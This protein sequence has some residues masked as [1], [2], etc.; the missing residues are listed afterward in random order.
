MIATGPAG[1]GIWHVEFC[2]PEKRN[3]LGVASYAAFADALAAASAMADVRVVL[4][5]GQGST[6]CAGND[7]AE[8]ATEW[9]QPAGGPVIRFLHALA[10]VPVPVVAAVQGGA[11]GIGATM[12]LHCDVIVA[13]PDAFLRYPFTDRGIAP[14]GASSLLLPRLVG[15][16]R[17][18]ELLLTGRRVDAGE[19]LTLGLV[20]HVSAARQQFEQALEIAHQLAAKPKDAVVATKRLLRQEMA[21]AVLARFDQEIGTINQLLLAGRS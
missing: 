8:F 2:Y 3:A 12:L 15:P 4:M 19:A 5:S 20:S 7:I 21:D 17:A 13:A 9:P 1:N 18:T 11:I 6:F 10:K 16:L 14:E